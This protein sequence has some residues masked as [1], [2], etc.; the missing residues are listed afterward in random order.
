MTRYELLLFVHVVA[1]IVWLGAA[2]VVQIF[3]A[4]ANRATDPMD[5]HRV[6]ADAEWLALRVFIPASLVVLIAGLL[7]VGVRMSRVL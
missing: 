4:R 1:A 5:M 2:T 3:A 6:A 7:L